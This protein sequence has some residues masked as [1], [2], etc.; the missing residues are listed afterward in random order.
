MQKSFQVVSKLFTQFL[1]EVLQSP[2]VR[3][4]SFVIFC[5]TS[6]STH[7]SKE[8]SPQT[9]TLWQRHKTFPNFSKR[10]T[11]MFFKSLCYGIA[12]Y[13]VTRRNKERLYGSPYSYRALSWKSV[14]RIR[15]ISNVLVY[16]LW[17]VWIIDHNNVE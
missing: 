11:E 17:L 16:V 15:L 7:A 14:T 5:F 13:Y 3:A 10:G 1:Q 2:I 4:L 9:K 6:T 12:I 8:L